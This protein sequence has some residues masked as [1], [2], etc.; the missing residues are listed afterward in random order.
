MNEH[1][2]ILVVVRLSVNAWICVLAL[3]LTAEAGMVADGE[4]LPDGNVVLLLPDTAT[5]RLENPAGQVIR[6]FGAEGRGTGEFRHP[7]GVAA[8][9]GSLLVADT[10]NHRVQVFASDGSFRQV[11]PLD[12]LAPEDVAVIG[13]TV[14]IADTG[15]DRLVVT[16]LQGTTV[17]TI[18][19]RG[20]EP[21]QFRSPRR[22][23]PMDGGVVVLDTLNRRV[24]RID[25]DTETAVGIDLPSGY[26]TALARDADGLL[27]ATNAPEVFRL[28]ESTW[29]QVATT[30]QLENAGL[31]DI[32][33]ILP[34]SQGLEVVDGSTG[35]RLRLDP[36]AKGT[37]P[38]P[39]PAPD[40]GDGDAVLVETEPESRGEP[41]PLPE[42]LPLNR[43]R[44]GT[45][46]DLGVPGLLRRGAIVALLGSVLAAGLGFRRKG[47]PE[48]E[49]C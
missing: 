12:L 46:D 2:R 37:V 43:I 25:L 31:N 28:R 42:D 6:Q 33:T 26:P 23:V 19:T 1:G 17:R 29:F 18:G 8:T 16:D 4:V 9:S 24:Q 15:H 3:A 11:L 34:G 7:S 13:E 22:L 35:A 47:R 36:D 14:V 21:G 38:L 20:G 48:G 41:P 32:A 40:K 39:T 45:S 49:D 30:E 27:V 5:I 44:S 10:W